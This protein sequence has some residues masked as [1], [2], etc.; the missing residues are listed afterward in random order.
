MF[1]R[2]GISLVLVLA[3]FNLLSGCRSHPEPKK[4]YAHEGSADPEEAWPQSGGPDAPAPYRGARARESQQSVSA[5]TP[6][7]PPNRPIDRPLDP[8]GL[9]LSSPTP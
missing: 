7:P 3:A 5:S 9:P 8:T 6:T 4:Q 1:F 2:Q